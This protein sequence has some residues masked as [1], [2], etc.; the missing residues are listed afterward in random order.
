[1]LLGN[2]GTHAERGMF[3]SEA[4]KRT[5]WYL[6]PELAAELGERCR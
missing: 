6:P 3:A 4:G 1:V 5:G 2:A